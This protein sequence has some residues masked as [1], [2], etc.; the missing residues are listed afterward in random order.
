[1]VFTSSIEW[2]KDSDQTGHIMN[3]TVMMTTQLILKFPTTARSQTSQGIIPPSK[4]SWTSR[5][6]LFMMQS[7]LVPFSISQ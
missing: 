3:K 7:W 2:A 5:K 1:M 4:L 6:A